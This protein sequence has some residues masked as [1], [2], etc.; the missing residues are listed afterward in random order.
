MA[1]PEVK[2]TRDLTVGCRGQDVVAHKRAISR[3]APNLYPWH[4]FTELCGKPFMRAVVAWKRSKKL[5]TVPRLGLSAH[6]ALERTRAKKKPDEWA[7]DPHSI[8][9]CQEYWKQHQQAPAE[10][11]REKGVSAGMFWYAHRNHIAYSQYRPFSLGKPAWIPSRWDCSAFATACHYAAG[12]P[13]PNGRGYDHQGYTGTLIDHGI[14]M[15]SV[16]DLKPLDLIFYGSSRGGPGFGR[17]APTHVAVYV[18]VRNGVPMVL[19]HGHYPMSYYAYNYRSD[20][21]QFRHYNI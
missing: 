15:G 13:D 4:D 5:S 12:A 21:N 11:K 14:R 8:A 19:S 16:R 2:F 9:L 20:I 18:G 7:F 17:G 10:A 6:N 1:P 3:A